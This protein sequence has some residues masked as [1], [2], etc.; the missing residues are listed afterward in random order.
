ME[1]ICYPFFF[2][3]RT[4]NTKWKPHDLYQIIQNLLW[5]D[6][7]R[8]EVLHKHSL[9]AETT[10]TQEQCAECYQEYFSWFQKNELRA[11]QRSKDITSYMSARMHND[12]GNRF[13][14]Y[15]TWKFGLPT[16]GEPL[17]QA[18]RH[19]AM[20]QSAL[21]EQDQRYVREHVNRCIRWCQ[22]VAQDIRL[23]KMTDKYKE[24][25]RK[26]GSRHQ[27]GLNDTELAARQLKR[28]QQQQQ[29]RGRR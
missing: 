23:R 1:E 5:Y 25:K 20:L 3:E 9:P 16:M 10:L 14:V 22:L 12:V 6:R 8:Q 24:D 7:F 11:N 28:Q 26:S 27:T 2:A 29:R 13:A 19:A 18:C 17:R 15:S 21:F 4:D